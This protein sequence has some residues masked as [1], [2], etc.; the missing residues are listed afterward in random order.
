MQPIS[1][2]Q[3]LPIIRLLNGWA[4]SSLDFCFIHTPHNAVPL[5]HP[6]HCPTLPPRWALTTIGWNSSPVSVNLS[7]RYLLSCVI[8][9]DGG[10]EGWNIWLLV[11]I[12]D[13]WLENFL[14]ETVDRAWAAGTKV[15][16]A[17]HRHN[18]VF[19]M[20]MTFMIIRKLMMIMLVYQGIGRRRSLGPHKSWSTPQEMPP[21]QPH[22]SW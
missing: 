10:L 15:Q 11:G 22:P 3:P 16:R 7:T 6:H 19:I 2:P 9:F 21:R 1:T 17:D 5:S 14:V 20:F 18:E 8:I 12:F 13:C 4:S